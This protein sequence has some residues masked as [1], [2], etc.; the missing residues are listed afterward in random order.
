MYEI[1]Y[2]PL[3]ESDLKQLNNSIRIEVFK[4]LKKLQESPELGKP[5]GNKNNMNLTGLLK[6]Y[7]A[8]KQVRI[9]YEV[10]E[11]ILVIKVIAIGK[12]ESMEVYKQA[13]VRR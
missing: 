11:N 1:K 8:K 6:V 9:V 4:K 13:Q 10:I 5:L 2:H 3:V 12:R 7:V